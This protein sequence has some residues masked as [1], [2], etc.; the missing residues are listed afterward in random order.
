[1]H[2]PFQGFLEL[3]RLVRLESRQRTA[4]RKH[5]FLAIP[6]HYLRG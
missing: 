2:E 5:L 3:V 1:L 4:G 6:N